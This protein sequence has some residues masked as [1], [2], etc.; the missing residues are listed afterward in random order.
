[1]V[2]LSTILGRFPTQE[3]YKAAVEGINLT[4]FAPPSKDLARPSIPLKAI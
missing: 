4:S 3:K 1:M 2:V